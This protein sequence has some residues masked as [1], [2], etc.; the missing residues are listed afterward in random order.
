MHRARSAHGLLY[1]PSKPTCR[2]PVHPPLLS[3]MPRPCASAWRT[4]RN[5]LPRAL[6]APSGCSGSPSVTHVICLARAMCMRRLQ[7]I[8]SGFWGSTIHVPFYR[9]VHCAIF[10]EMRNNRTVTVTDLFGPG[11]RRRRCCRSSRISSQRIHQV[12]MRVNLN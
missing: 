3:T 12:L 11:R 7:C 8:I 2:D 1:M 5:A 6:H 10:T 4:W 9:L